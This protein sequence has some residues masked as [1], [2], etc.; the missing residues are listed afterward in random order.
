MVELSILQSMSEFR[1]L[2]KNQRARLSCALTYAL[3]I[4]I[5]YGSSVGTAH[6]HDGLSTWNPQPVV[7]SESNNSPTAV[8]RGHSS[9]GP[10]RPGDCQICQFRQ[11]LSNGAI[12][13]LVLIQAPTASSPVIPVFSVSLSS[14]AQTTRQGRAPP[15][16]S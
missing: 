4:L 1:S 9:D 11:S 16:I 5:S 8:D 13:T 14:T 15:V 12:F 2:P 6:R 3:L 10:A 7:S